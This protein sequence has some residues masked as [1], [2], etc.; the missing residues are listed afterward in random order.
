MFKKT[1]SIVSIIVSF[2]RFLLIKLIRPRFRFSAIE[3]FSPNTMI[4]IHRGGALRLGKNV[5]AHTGSR[6]S[7]TRDGLMEIGDGTALNYNCIFVARKHISIGKNVS[8]GPNVVIYDHDHDY[9]ATSQSNEDAYKCS[10]II[11]GDNVWVGANVV[12]LRG[13]R[14]GDNAVVAAGTVVRGDVAANSVA[15]NK[16]ELV[17]KPY[18]KNGPNSS[19]AE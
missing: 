7:V 11:I 1:K 17:V 2:F 10:D 9:K 6:L 3:R 15:Y 4:N 14:I 16:K 19:D 12:I 13:S 8:F 18:E 5:R